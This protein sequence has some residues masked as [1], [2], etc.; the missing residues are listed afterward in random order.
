MDLEIDR[1]SDEVRENES[2]EVKIKCRKS[3]RC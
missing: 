2:K 3:N 1:D